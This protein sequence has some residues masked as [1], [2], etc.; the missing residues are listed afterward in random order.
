MASKQ[1]AACI[2]LTTLAREEGG[3][4]DPGRKL[5]AVST[6]T[7][8]PYSGAVFE[9]VLGTANVVVFSNL[10]ECTMSPV[11]QR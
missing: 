9:T 1:T 11:P 10:S 8:G 5:A 3:K 7:S 6:D 2:Q 4:P